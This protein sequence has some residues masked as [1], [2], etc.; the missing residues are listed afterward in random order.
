[1]AKIEICLRAIVENI[2][3]SMLLGRHR[4]WINIEVRV[5]FLDHDRMATVLEKGA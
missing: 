2:D 1:M 3:F 4:A 5:K